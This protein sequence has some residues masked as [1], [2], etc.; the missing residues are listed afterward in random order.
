MTNF[1]F[2][3]FRKA[4]P[5]L[6]RKQFQFR[7]K[8]NE[9]IYFLSLRTFVFHLKVVSKPFSKVLAKTKFGFKM[10]WKCCLPFSKNGFNFVTQKFAKKGKLQLLNTQNIHLWPRGSFKPI[11]KMLPTSQKIASTSLLKCLQKRKKY[12]FW[13]LRKCFSPQGC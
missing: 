3:Q 11:S 4:L 12:H 7:C 1:G 6:P 2:K 13:T 10:N 9:K 8:K 5:F